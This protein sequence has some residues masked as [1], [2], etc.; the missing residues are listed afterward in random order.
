MPGGSDA[1]PD[2]GGVTTVSHNL[3]A[4]C[5]ANADCGTGLTCLAATGKDVAGVA[6]PANG[7]CSLVCNDTATST[8]CTSAGGHCLSLDGSQTQGLCMLGCT[9]GGTDN[10][11]KCNQRPDV[12][13]VSLMAG[14]GA[15][16]PVCTEDTDCPAGRKCDESASMC[17]DAADATKGQA[18]GTHCAADANNND[19]CSGVCIQVG[20]TANMPIAAF[21]S[22]SCVFGTLETS[23][24]WLAKGMSVTGGEHG[25]CFPSD[26]NAGPGDLGLCVQLCDATTDCSNQTDPML[27]CDQAN[28]GIIQHGLCFWGTPTA[29]DGGTD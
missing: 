2:T 3:G 27:V 17:V 12:A 6:G 5:T 4:T 11:N 25:A 29:A 7:Y 20:N 13:C 8:A 14:G 21:C 16:I 9:P 26:P 28:A 18:F 23:C 24:G 22:R 10:T 15:C 1:H 19:P